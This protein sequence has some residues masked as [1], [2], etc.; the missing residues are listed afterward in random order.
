MTDSMF[1]G[2]TGNAEPSVG[3]PGPGSLHIM[4]VEDNADSREMLCEL[5]TLLG[6]RVR[7]AADA[8]AADAQLEQTRVQV[9]LTDISLPCMSGVEL[10]RKS[11]ER[12]P[13]LTVI[14]VSGYGSAPDADFPYQSLRKPYDLMQLQ[15]LLAEVATRRQGT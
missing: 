13:D 3:K 15:T 14:F 9:L 11:R 5:L 2:A 7:S 12:D 8:E 4:V 1:T 6:H 10:A